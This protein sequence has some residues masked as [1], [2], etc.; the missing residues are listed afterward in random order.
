[1]LGDMI[2][3]FLRYIRFKKVRVDGRIWIFVEITQMK[4]PKLLKQNTR[5][6][7]NKTVENTKTKPLKILK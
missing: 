7:S 1:M 6:Y 4:M 2:W 3:I 5:N